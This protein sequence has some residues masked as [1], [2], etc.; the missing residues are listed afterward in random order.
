VHTLRILNH[1]LAFVTSWLHDFTETR[2]VSKNGSDW[3]LLGNYKIIGAKGKV[4]GVV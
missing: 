2:I 1:A 4:T 3:L